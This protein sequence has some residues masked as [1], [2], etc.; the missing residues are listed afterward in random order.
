MSVSEP[1]V[2]IEDVGDDMLSSSDELVSISMVAIL[3]G[4]VAIFVEERGD[5]FEPMKSGDW[6][7]IGLAGARGNS[8]CG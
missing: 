4:C 5:G 6:A 7:F 3:M 2:V 1:S 8:L